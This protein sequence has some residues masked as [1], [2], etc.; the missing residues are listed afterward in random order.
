MTVS[1]P[2]VLGSFW[3]LLPAA[4]VAALLVARTHLE[5]RYLREKLPGYTNYVR[6]VRYRLLP[7]VW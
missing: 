3:G 6:S 2:L 5:D 1:M 7:R 4:A